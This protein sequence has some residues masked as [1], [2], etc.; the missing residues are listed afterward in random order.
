VSVIEFDSK[1]KKSFI[2]IYKNGVMYISDSF[3]SKRL[4][5]QYDHLVFLY[6]PTSL[7]LFMAFNK[8]GKGHRIPDH[9]VICLHH[10]LN[11]FKVNI[12][13]NSGQFLPEF[14]EE[15]PNCSLWSLQLEEDMSQYESI[16]Q[17][18]SSG[19]KSVTVD[20]IVHEHFERLKA[21]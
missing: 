13:F 6:D 9:R 3:L 7:K 17:T 18:K 16:M 21:S 19:I 5:D 12:S 1:S 20:S 15:H 2:S 4:G 8:N 10:M 14:H 11:N